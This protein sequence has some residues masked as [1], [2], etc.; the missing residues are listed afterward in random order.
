VLGDT[1]PAI[2]AEKLGLLKAGAPLFCAVPAGLKA[3]VFAAGVAAGAPVHFLD[4]QARIEE[5]ADGV[6]ELVT[7]RARLGGLP[8]L[9]APWLRANAALA[10]LC[11]E[12]LAATG[13]ARRAA[14]P[15]AALASVFLPGRHQRVLTDPDWV[16]D[17][18]H[19]GQ[20]LTAALATFLARP[21]GGRR[22]AIFGCLREKS[23]DAGVGELLRR[24][25]RVVA[26]PPRL[27]RARDAA[28]LAGLL[29]GWNVGGTA[30]PEVAR[31]LGE[32]IGRV[33][34]AAR[35]D[36]A[37]LVTGSGFVVAE[38]LWRLGFRDLRQT[39]A[40]RPAAEVLRELR[41]PAAG[42]TAGTEAR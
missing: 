16:F 3:Q 10:L 13:V 23:L 40:P 30:G 35:P 28:D 2:A 7:R 17:T 42:P 26:A 31:D 12:E 21:V 1:L 20:A 19:N 27:P 6:W 11:V 18:A 38:T 37:V 25:D 5:R 22:F 29:R 8:P 4:E 33:A 41:A 32:A 15:A 24:C 34:A 39:R 36:D 9:A 14:D